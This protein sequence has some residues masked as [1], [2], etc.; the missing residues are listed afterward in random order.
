MKSYREAGVDIDA[1]NLTVRLL[2]EA[3]SSTTT[4]A[5]LS[6]IGAFGG[7]FAADDLGPGKVLVA[8]TDGVGTKVDLAARY[9]RYKG[10]GLDLVNHCVNDILVQGARPLF[11]LDYIATAS[12]VPETVLEIVSGM[13]EACKAVGCAL[14]G[15]E[16]AEMPGVYMPGATDIAGTIVGVVDREALWPKTEQLS[17]G[18]LLVGL[19]S[20]GPHTNGY[21][22]I[23]L[24]LEQ[25][26]ADE[27]MLE[28]LLAPHKCYI[29]D[30]DCLQQRG[31]QPKALAHITGGGV[32]ENLPRVLPDDLSARIDLGSWDVPRPFS[33]LT[34]WADLPNDEAFRVWNMGIGM[35]VVVDRAQQPL[36][37][38]LGLATVGHLFPSEGVQSEG[39]QSEGVSGESPERVR[40][41]GDWR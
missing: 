20:V 14:L 39:V 8:S 22:L 33:T 9:R 40:L 41:V 13:S 31:V 6:E 1:G 35:I 23:R 16:T 4:P 2:A 26:E 36:I 28:F 12:L 25:H 30:I 15:G 19:S 21:S 34:K 27:E 5:V 17:A 18:D 10:L 38:E 29:G 32:I 24:L 37:E 7:L 11:F 3:V